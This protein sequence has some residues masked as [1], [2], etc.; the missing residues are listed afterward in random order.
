V[1]DTSPVSTPRAWRAGGILSWLLVAAILVTRP[2][3]VDGRPPTGD[4]VSSLVSAYFRVHPELA[5]GRGWAPEAMELRPLGPELLQ[6]RDTL[7]STLRRLDS[8]EERPGPTFARRRSLRCWVESELLRLESLAVL[9]T[10]AATYVAHARRLLEALRETPG[11]GREARQQAWDDTLARLTGYLKDARLSLVDPN[12]L[13]IEGALV[14]L[15]RLEELL[16][17]PGSP[18]ADDAQPEGDPRKA[19][20]LFRLWLERQHQRVTAEPQRM[21]ADWGR[22]VQLVTGTTRDPRAVKALLLR[23][24]AALDGPVPE[25]AIASTP[26]SIPTEVLQRGFSSTSNNAL[27]LA[28]M[29]EVLDPGPRADRLHL[30]TRESWPDEIRNVVPGWSS[31]HEEELVLLLPSAAWSAERGAERLSEYFPPQ[32]MALALRHGMVGEALYSIT[33]RDDPRPFASTVVREPL[34]SGFGLFA[35]DWIPRLAHEESP[36]VG[37]VQLARAIAAQQSLE[38][39]RLLASLELHVEGQSVDEALMGFV[40]RTGLDP[41]RARAEVH[42]A[43]VD[44][45]LGLGALV[46]LELHDVEASLGRLLGPGKAL[47]RL[48]RLVLDN[49]DLRPADLPGAL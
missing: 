40:R 2:L 27:A 47:P 4:A 28:R 32:L 10:D 17:R 21:G 15:G 29:L 38:I 41:D 18:A 26:R 6:W 33:T 9:R 37:D 46:R 48:L 39:A 34:R 49:P 23:E 30:V 13:S 36:F 42:R 20:A 45:A 22:Y 11:L 3:P 8:E 25:P 44:P 5:L 31:P 1:L 24:L 12:Q 43:L 14:E 7:R 35:L 16:S 19:I